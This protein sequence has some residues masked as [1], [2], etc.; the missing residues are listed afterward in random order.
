MEMTKEQI[1]D[2][3]IKEYEELLAKKAELKKEAE[4]TDEAVKKK[5][6]ELAHAISD[7]EMKQA[8]SAEYGYTYTPG[9]QHKYY[10]KKWE[11]LPEEVDDPF[12][13]FENDETLCGLIKREINWRR[14]QS[15]MQELEDTEEGIPDEIMAVL[16][17]T[18]EFGISR[19]KAD[20]KN[21]NKVKAAIENQKKGEE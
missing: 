6:D 17:I 20:M 7:A 14:L 16:N 13:P 12:A 21:Y 15:A 5:A 18:D 2:Q 9:V 3:K 4:A 8:F 10:M 1:V 11:D 19:K